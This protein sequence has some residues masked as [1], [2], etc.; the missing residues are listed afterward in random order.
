MGK[1]VLVVED[2]RDNREI[3]IEFLSAYGFNVISAVDG[4]EGI[5]LFKAEKPD[6][7]LSDVLLPKV[8][9]FGVCQ[10]IKNTDNPVPVILMSALYKTHALQAEAREKYGA[11]DYVLKPLNLVGLAERIC[12]LIGVDKCNLNLESDNPVD[13]FACPACSTFDD[14]PPSLV[15]AT[16]FMLKETG[17][18]TCVGKY[19][20]VVYLDNGVPIFVN[21]NNPNETYGALLVRDGKLSAEDKDRLELNAKEKKT[22][23]G[24]HLINEKLLSSREVSEY[25]IMEVHERLVDLISWTRGEY[26]FIADDS[27]KSKIN[28]PPMAFC[29][30][31]YLGV[32]RAR[33]YEYLNE[34]YLPKTQ[35]VIYKVETNLTRVAE[36]N[37]EMPDLDVFMLIDGENTLY[38]LLSEKKTKPEDTYKLVYILDLLG[39]IVI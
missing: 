6:L 26:N 9:G 13:E 10:A 32:K 17:V 5:D 12:S 27:F 23:L 18:L 33:L 25:M 3:I 11:D 19:K 30:A 1:T 35:K 20:K 7:V 38:H 21:S 15:L 29:N 31:L 36:L 4:Q 14:Y 37:L 39:I 24:K 34:R 16:Y 2:N 28:R 22:T 8:N